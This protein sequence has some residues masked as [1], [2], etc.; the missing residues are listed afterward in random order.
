MNLRRLGAAIGPVAGLVAVYAVFAL[1]GPSSF[2]TAANLE[3]IARQTAIVGAAAL[4]ATLVIV[5]GGIDLS[6][7][8]IVACGTVV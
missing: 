2:S 1:F 5:A 8:S 6:I 7:G 4:G 3:T